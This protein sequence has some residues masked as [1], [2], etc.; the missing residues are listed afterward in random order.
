M[1]QRQMLL[2]AFSLESPEQHLVAP[3]PS[4]FFAPLNDDISG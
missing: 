2:K 1:L 4:G 3:A